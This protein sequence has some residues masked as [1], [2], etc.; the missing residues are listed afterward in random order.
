M[1]SSPKILY[2]AHSNQRHGFGVKSRLVRPYML[3]QSHPCLELNYVQGKSNVNVENELIMYMDHNNLTVDL[4]F[5]LN[6]E[7]RKT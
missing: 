6:D 4:E 3:C 5:F 2:T 1:L 7:Q